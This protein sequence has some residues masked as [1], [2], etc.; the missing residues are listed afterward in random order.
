MAE[1]NIVDIFGGDEKAALDTYM[2]IMAS[3]LLITLANDYMNDA[4][5]EL[6][7]RGLK[8]QKTKQLFNTTQKWFKEYNQHLQ[9]MLPNKTLAYAYLDDFDELRAVIDGF[10]L[11]Q[12]RM[13]EVEDE[14]AESQVTE[15]QQ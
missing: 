7:K 10:I 15:N 5:E 6:A 9:K 4:T 12:N 2:G 3:Y 11:G 8:V 14:D 13:R 1:R